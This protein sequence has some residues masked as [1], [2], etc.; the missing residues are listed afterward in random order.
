MKLL[1]KDVMRTRVEAG[2]RGIFKSET[3]TTMPICL[4]F[5]HK[6]LQLDHVVG[7]EVITEEDA[8]CVAIKPVLCAIIAGCMYVFPK[9][10]MLP[11]QT[12]LHYF[13]ATKCFP[14]YKKYR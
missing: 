8:K 13:I 14:T 4:F 2:G 3:T 7:K 9:R 11:N 12:A 10:E 1:S 5:V 6:V